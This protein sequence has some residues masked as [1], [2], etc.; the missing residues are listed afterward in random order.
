MCV[1]RRLS[2]VVLGTTEFTL[3]CA[4][5]IRRSGG[6]V[7]ALITLPEHLKPENSTDFASYA[8]ENDIELIE[9]SDLNSAEAIEHLKRLD[10]DYIFSTWPHLLS[11]EFLRAPKN[12]VIGSHPTPLPIGRGRH[13]L[14]WLTVL[15]I[16][17]TCLSFFIMDNGIDTGQL[18]FQQPFRVEDRIFD[19]NQRM[20]G[21][22]YKAF[23]KLLG[24][25]LDGD[26]P[27]S[28]TNS[29]CFSNYWR[30]RDFHDIT[31]D[32][33]MP[34]AVARRIVNSFM[35][36]YSGARLYIGVDEYL[37][38]VHIRKVTEGACLDHWALREHGYVFE[39]YHDR[40]L[41]RFDDAVLSLN[42]SSTLYRN[43]A[44]N[45][46]HPPS[47]YLHQ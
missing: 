47:F 26:P 37:V 22:V 11:E 38:I 42:F 12:F 13:A 23:P 36:P 43:L 15:N 9:Y 33:R 7:R 19:T 41:I 44:G 6:E 2:F 17:E 39:S 40:I 28:Q 5:A 27:V 25:L 16:R 35:P 29:E 34:S 24:K 20:I 45:K 18:L 30:K 46:L 31:L 32:P 8:Q 10:V 21:A 3:A 1:S 4:D 14:H